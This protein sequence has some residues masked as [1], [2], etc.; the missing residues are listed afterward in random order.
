MYGRNL[1][2]TISSK[3]LDDALATGSCGIGLI[4]DFYIY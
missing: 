2:T 1:D 3:D 4:E